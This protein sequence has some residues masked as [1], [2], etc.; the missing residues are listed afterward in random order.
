MAKKKSSSE[1]FKLAAAIRAVLSENRNLSGREVLD[2]VKQK[3]PHQA[4]NKNSFNVSFYTARKGLG[5][6]SGRRHKV[7]RVV[8]P[9]PARKMSG[10]AMSLELLQ[11]VRRMLAVAGDAETA[12][13]AIR[14]LQSLQIR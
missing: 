5:I 2:A 9:G 6:K 8:T 7:V 14:Q 10:T 13:A 3:H 12:V 11:A 4:I 1:T